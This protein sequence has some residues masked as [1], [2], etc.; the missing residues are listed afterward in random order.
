MMAD[1]GRRG[2]DRAETSISTP[3]RS[4]TGDPITDALVPTA[5]DFMVA[6]QD[7]EYGD[8]PAIREE[9]EK[10]VRRYSAEAIANDHVAITAAWGIAMVCGSWNDV[11]TT[12]PA[13]LAW[14]RN[15]EEYKRLRAAGVDAIAAGELAAQYAQRGD[16]A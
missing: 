4:L 1:S 11:L 5:M 14:L 8:L 6:V 16:A 2:P 3:T 10:A 13:A 15:R 12:P 9:A 7:E